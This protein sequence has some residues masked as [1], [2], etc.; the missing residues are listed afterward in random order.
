VRQVV[1]DG[2]KT[3]FLFPPTVTSVDAPLIRLIGPNGPEIVHA[4]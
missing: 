1:D 4:R 2:Y 3:S